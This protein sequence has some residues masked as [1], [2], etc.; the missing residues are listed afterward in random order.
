MSDTVISDRT[1]PINK[2]S[3]GASVI[4]KSTEGVLRPRRLR[5]AIPRCQA[6]QRG[7]SVACSQT[8]PQG[9]KEERNSPF[10]LGRNQAETLGAMCHQS[11]P[12]LLL[13][14]LFTPY[15]GHSQDWCRWEFSR[16]FPECPVMQASF[17]A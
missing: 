8:Q 12:A 4:C 1:T 15:L 17:S 3:L 16:D 9:R 11:F 10:S 7:K 6:Q 5:A 2:S 14:S 13:W